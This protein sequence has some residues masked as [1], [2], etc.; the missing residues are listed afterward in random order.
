MNASFEYITT[1]EYRLKTAAAEVAAFK[2]GEKYVRIPERT[3][4]FRAQNQEIRRRTVCFPQRD[5]HGPE[6]V[7]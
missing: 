7:V 6:A 5:R 4:S 1:L 3:P 2:S